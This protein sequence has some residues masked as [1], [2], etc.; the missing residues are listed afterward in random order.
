M[1]VD[2]E[3]DERMRAGRSAC[4]EEGRQM[5][6][7]DGVKEK[8]RPHPFIKILALPAKRL[9]PFALP[10]QL[11]RAGPGAGAL[12]RPM[13]KLWVC[14][15]NDFDQ[16]RHKALAHFN[17]RRASNSTRPVSTSSRSSPSKARANWAVNSPYLTPM[18]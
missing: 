14:R 9:Q 12:Q 18:S 8:K 11:R 13:T 15:R 4:L 2:A 3:R 5:K 17:S 6:P 10:E 7:V 16:V 1:L